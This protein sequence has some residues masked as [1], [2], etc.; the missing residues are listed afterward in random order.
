MCS[1]TSIIQGAREKLE[2]ALATRPWDAVAANN[3]AVAA[4]YAGDLGGAVR[5]LARARHS[6]ARHSRAP[7]PGT[8]AI[9]RRKTESES[10]Q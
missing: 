6:R 5:T 3:A 2:A 1:H 8:H 10:V 7:P 4:L 9:V